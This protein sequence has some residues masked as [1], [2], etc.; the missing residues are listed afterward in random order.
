[1]NFPGNGSNPR[2][3]TNGRA[4][5]IIG[6]SSTGAGNNGVPGTT[7]NE[8]N[9]SFG[10]A[11][12]GTDPTHLTPDDSQNSVAHHMN[13]NSSNLQV[14]ELNNSENNGSSGPQPPILQVN[15]TEPEKPVEINTTADT[16]EAS[17]INDE[18]DVASTGAASVAGGG[19]ENAGTGEKGK[20]KKF[21]LFGKKKNKSKK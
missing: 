8:L 17:E 19:D 13:G 7:G 15:G 1:M 5:G 11:N 20:K 3:A 10:S 21:G 18:K 14:P 2:L 9:K 16:N 12:S 4:P 6:P